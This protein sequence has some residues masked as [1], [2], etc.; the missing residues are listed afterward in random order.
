[1]KIRSY[2]SIPESEFLSRL[3]RTRLRG[4]GQPYLY[5][6]AS[7]EI[8]EAVDPARLAPAQRYVLRADCATVEALHRAFL[9]ESIDIFALQGAI[10]FTPKGQDEEIPC[11][12]P[13]VEES[14][15]PDGRRLLLINDGIHRVYAAKKL[16][17]PINIA[18]VRQVPPEYPYYALALTNGW[19]DVEELDELP[20]NYLKKTYRDPEGY[21][22]L[23]RDFNEVFPGVQKQRKQSNPKHLTA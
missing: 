7:L 2:R 6:N 3:R 16:G 21:K 9:E 23:F 20:D 22:S 5:E 17:L 13:I 14:L 8:L 4:H 19:D 11:T 1:M 15:E 10:F 18:L 12:P